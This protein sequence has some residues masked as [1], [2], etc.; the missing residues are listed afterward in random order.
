M[1]KTLIEYMK[2]HHIEGEYLSFKASCHS[3]AEAAEA[4]GAPMSHFVKNICY[5]NTQNHHLI[6]AIVKGEHRASSKRIAKRLDIPLPRIAT[7]EEMLLLTG[8]PCGGIPS[9]GYT[10]T[11]IVDDK[12]LELD[13]V[14]TGGGS[15][16]ALI[17]ISVASLLEA[18]HA[19]V[20]RIRK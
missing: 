5:I 20:A 3:V 14:Y 7:E 10:A 16:N 18:N 17:K 12:V 19:L 8:F 15:E 13:N 6:V 2:H 9:F 1:S 11:F 4:S